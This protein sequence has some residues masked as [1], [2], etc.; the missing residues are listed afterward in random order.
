LIIL[1]LELFFFTSSSLAAAV[2]FLSSL[3]EVKSEMWHDLGAHFKL[4]R[5]TDSAVED[6]LSSRFR[7]DADAPIPRALR[8]AN[9]R[10]VREF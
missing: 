7:H 4:Y 2:L 1:A 6:K 8:I 5:I 10:A 3:K 9:C